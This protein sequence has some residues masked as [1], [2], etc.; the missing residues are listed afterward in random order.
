MCSLISQASHD[1]PVGT[2][3][4]YDHY[5][6]IETSLPWPGLLEE[7]GRIGKDLLHVMEEARTRGV[8]FRP[9]AIAPDSEYSRSG[10]RRVLFFS[11]P[12]GRFSV[13]R[14]HEYAV[15]Q[16]MVAPLV[17]AYLNQT[18]RLERFEAY[19]E[20]ADGDGERGRVRDLLVCTHGSVDACCGKFGFPIYKT[21][22]ESYCSSG[23]P[24]I[25]VWRVSHFGG[26]RFAP[27]LLDFPE[28]RYW[29]HLSPE[30]LEPLVNRSDSFAPLRPHYRGWVG[31][32]TPF[33]Q[34]AEAAL[35]M[36]E[37]WAWSDYPKV[38]KLLSVDDDKRCAR[39]QLEVE[40]PGGEVSFCE[41]E[42]HVTEVVRARGSCTHD[43]PIEVPR[44]SEV[45]WITAPLSTTA[46]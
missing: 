18:E 2:A 7:T 23:S 42:V 33:E 25:R 15:P 9:L 20:N 32:K 12:S 19:R 3:T 10:H 31:L 1:D 5:A 4:S 30:S 14:R 28:G 41:A 46:V 34:V 45:R 38:G 16:S 26:H 22:R 24:S 35:L 36:R 13:L 37:G 44:Y 11:R 21:L 17:A 43:E 29:G 8:H 6:I 40:L 27:T 39:L